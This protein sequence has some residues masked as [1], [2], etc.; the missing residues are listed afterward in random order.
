MP[1]FTFNQGTTGTYAGVISGTGSLTKDGAGTLTLSGA[2]PTQAA[3]PSPPA[4]VGHDHQP[5][6]QHHQQ[7]QPHLQQT[8]TGTTQASSP[9]RA[10]SPKPAVAPSCSPA[11]TPTRAAP[12]SRGTLQVAMAAP[13]APSRRRDR[14]TDSGLNRSDDISFGRHSGTGRA[15]TRANTLTSRAP[16][17]TAAYHRSAALC[18]QTPACRATYRQRQPHFQPDHHDLLSVI[19]GTGILTKAAAAPSDST[20][21]PIPAHHHFAAPCRS[22]MRGRRV[23]HG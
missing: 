4:L 20:T 3:P 9:A 19:S 16:T 7:R 5:P 22:A 13:P 21:T 10:R 14:P 1:T 15:P 6:R 8:T 23:D 11:A 17:L 18:R 2:T 12:P